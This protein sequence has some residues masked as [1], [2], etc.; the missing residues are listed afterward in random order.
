MGFRGGTWTTSQFFFSR[1]A[2]L[3]LEQLSNILEIEKTFEGA[4]RVTRKPQDAQLVV[5]SGQ[6]NLIK[7]Y[8]N[9]TC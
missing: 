3:L 6:K 1:C 2:K 4:G 7:G 9:T 8:Q 5:I